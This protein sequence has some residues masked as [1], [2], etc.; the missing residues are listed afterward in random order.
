MAP[1]HPCPNCGNLRDGP[2][3]SCIECL[4]PN[5]KKQRA[6]VNGLTQL[7]HPPFRFHIRTLVLLTTI[8]ATVCAIT[9]SWGFDGLDLGLRIFA[10]LFPVIE[11]FYYFW[12]NLRS[13]KRNAIEE[14]E[15]RF[16]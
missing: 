10:F 16:W 11:F 9:K 1:R 6:Y 7:K 8:T 13:E 14:Y 4:Y 15:S 2:N 5:Q 3:I 12:I